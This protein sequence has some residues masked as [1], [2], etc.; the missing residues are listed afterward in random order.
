MKAVMRTLTAVLLL[1][2]AAPTLAA[3]DCEELKT[4]IAATLDAKGIKGYTLESIGKDA[5]SAGKTVVGRCEGGA[6]VIVYQR[7]GRMA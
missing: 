5:E 6:K 7:S 1:T 3:K 2:N 4:E